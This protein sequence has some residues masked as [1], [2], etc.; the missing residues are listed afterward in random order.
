MPQHGRRWSPTTSWRDTGLNAL[1]RCRC[2][3]QTDA[4]DRLGPCMNDELLSCHEQVKQP[5]HILDRLGAFFITKAVAGII[6][7]GQ[8]HN[9]AIDVKEERAWTGG[10]DHAGSH[11]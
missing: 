10:A 4:G 2:T 11:R 8:R 5:G 1:E 7:N 9:R 3:R 6:G